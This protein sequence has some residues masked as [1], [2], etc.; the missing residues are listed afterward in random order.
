MTPVQ[1]PADWAVIGEVADTRALETPL[2]AQTE[3]M[4]KSGTVAIPRTLP[5]VEV[6]HKGNL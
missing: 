3:R 6:E 2:D 4:F 5:G 1:Q